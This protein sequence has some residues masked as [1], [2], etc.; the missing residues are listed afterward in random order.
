MR[1]TR[2]IEEAAL[3]QRI[4]AVAP[5]AADL[6]FDILDEGWDS[7]AIAAGPWIF[8][9]PRAPEPAER[10][11]KEARLLALVRP[12]LT[13]RVPD[14]V[15]HQAG[16][17]FSQH[18]RIPGGHL[19]SADYARLGEA[20]RADLAR[21]IAIM[22]AELHD[23]PV[24]AAEAAGAEVLVPALTGEETLSRLRPVLPPPLLSFLEHTIAAHAAL[25]ENPREVF[26]HFDAHGWN[27][28][29]DH[30]SGRLNGVFD[31]GDAGLGPRHKD[32]GYTGFIAPDLT[33]RIVSDY[34]ALTGRAI[35]IERVMLYHS[36]LR[37]IETAEGVHPDTEIGV[38]A[39]AA[40][41]AQ[42]TPQ[43]AWGGA[44]KPAGDP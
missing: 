25:G 29:F 44:E 26:G 22:H 14:L 42:L 3:R 31:F 24:A 5:E 41:L 4:A 17:T 2:P 37:L 34:A 11:R 38:A 28:A 8:K 36:A 9:F 20:E 39:L 13:M 40:Y 16:G 30:A 43:E 6:A 10:L 7:L 27:M 35:A 23:I 33:R 19:T 32:L 15:L 1:S 12:R 18:L 21:S